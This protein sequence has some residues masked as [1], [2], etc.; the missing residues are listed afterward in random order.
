MSHCKSST[1]VSIS[2]TL[3]SELVTLSTNSLY[4]NKGKD[5]TESKLYTKSNCYTHKD[6]FEVFIIQILQLFLTHT[7]IH[8][9]TQALIF[10][11]QANANKQ[12]QENCT[13]MDILWWR[14]CRRVARSRSRMFSSSKVWFILTIS[15]WLSSSHAAN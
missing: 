3:V 6:I 1:V 8:I 4:C 7:L 5:M 9:H 2:D 10:P 14:P 12:Y 15:D 13:S 11:I